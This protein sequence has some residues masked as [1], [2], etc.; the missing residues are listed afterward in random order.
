[1]RP[2]RFMM[3]LGADRRQLPA[4]AP[5]YKSE[6]DVG[7]RQALGVHAEDAGD[8]R[9]RHQQRGQHR[10]YTQA[11]VALLFDLQMQLFLQQPAALAFPQWC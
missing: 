4:A 11:V 5:P 3:K 2:M 1:M 8:Q 6:F 9:R 7:E 10:Q